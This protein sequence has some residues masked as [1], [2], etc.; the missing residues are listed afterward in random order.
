MAYPGGPGGYNPQ[1][2][3]GQPAPQQGYGY[4]QYPGGAP[5]GY[6]GGY[7]NPGMPGG[8]PPGADPTLWNWFITVDADKSGEISTAELQKALM[9]SNWSHFNLETCRLM[10]GMF[11]R[12]QSGT[13]NFQEFSGLWRYIQQWK[14]SFDRYDRDR[15][16]SI[17]APE[18]SQAFSDMG[19]RLS[20]NFVQLIILKFDT[21]A[22]RCLKLD[23]FIQ[24]CVMLKCLTDAFRLRDTN[25]NG[26]IDVS[27]TGAAILIEALHVFGYCFGIKM[28]RPT[29]WQS[30]TTL[31]PVQ[32]IKSTDQIIRM[33]DG[34]SITVKI[35]N[36]GGQKLFVYWLFVDMYTLGQEEEM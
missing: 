16:G 21:H 27:S 28:A 26:T 35:W 4:G 34:L 33:E 1:G 31:E 19:Y 10:I 18:L 12:D 24:C 36:G 32:L 11:D 30:F 25:Q 9:N 8:A 7:Q 14:G 13:I 29:L 22:K 2:G 6:P 23:S 20:M 3:Y 17:E 15:S 5:Q